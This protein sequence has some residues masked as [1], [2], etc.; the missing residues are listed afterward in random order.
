LINVSR[1]VVVFLVVSLFSGQSF[2]QNQEINFKDLARSG[3]P[4]VKRYVVEGIESDGRDYLSKFDGADTDR[5]AAA[6]SRSSSYSSTSSSGSSSSSNGKRYSC[7][8]LCRGSLFATGSRYSVTAYGSSEEAAR[9]SVKS[10]A[11]K[12][13]YSANSSRGGAWWADFSSCKE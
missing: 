9:E 10:S 3:P 4:V 8:Y 6:R 12:A 1:N 7:S 13:C 5:I 11:D 2:A